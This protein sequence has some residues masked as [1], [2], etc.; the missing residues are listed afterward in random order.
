MIGMIIWLTSEIDDLAK[1]DA[2]DDPDGEIDDIATQRELLELLEH[3]HLHGVV[4]GRVA[5]TPKQKS[6][7]MSRLKGTLKPST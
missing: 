5:A 4:T 2:D 3:G 6:I 7:T 1:G